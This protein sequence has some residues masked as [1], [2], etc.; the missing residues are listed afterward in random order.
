MAENRKTYYEAPSTSVMEV[1]TEGMLCGSP[2]GTQDYYYGS[3][4][5]E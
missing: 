1:K 5:E 2:Y 4:D 3:M